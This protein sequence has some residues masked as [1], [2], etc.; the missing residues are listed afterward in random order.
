[1][2]KII[3]YSFLLSGLVMSGCKKYLETE[4]LSQASET[5]FWKT[6]DDAQTGLNAVYSTLPDSRDFWRDCHSDNSVMTNAWGEGGMGYICQGNQTPADTYISEEWAYADIRIALY[7]LDKLSAMDIDASMKKRFDA[8]AR[9]ILAM[10]YFRMTQLFGDIPLIKEKPVDLDASALPRS[11]KQE[12]LDYALQN[13]ETAVENLPESYSGADVGRITKGA[14]YLLKANIYL[15]MA[16]YKKFHENANDAALWTKAAEAADAVTTLGYDLEP[17]YSYLFKQQSNN[18]NTEVILAY[19]YVKDKL[20]QYLP[21]LAS[22]SGVGQTGEG[23]ASF[24]PTRDLIDSYE[25]TDGQSIETSPLYNKSNPFVNRD[26]RLAETFM[27]PGQP[28]IRPDGSTKPYNPHPSYNN[29]EKMN[30]EGGGLTGYMYLKFNDLTLLDPYTNYGNWPIYRYAEALLVLAEALNE[31]DPGNAKIQWAV[32]KIRA[33]AGLP[34]V[35]AIAGD[36]AKMR[37]AIREER[38]HEFVAEHKR[39]FDILRWKIAEDVLNVPAYGINSDVNDPIGDWTKP[40]FLA[41]DRHFDPAKHY[42]WPVPQTSIDKNNN[43]LPQNPNW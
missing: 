37:E 28:V 35:A 32:D 4:P 12:V 7:Y 27:L 16:S 19:Q 20:V 15:Y 17:D 24:C 3:A 29:P 6:V 26:K 5:T 34:G 8:E 1:M 43:L 40:K 2:K 31:Y 11:P 42:L 18:N 14:A 21:L 39:Y 41:Q 22:P 33:R 23:W 10:R 36:Q 13:V 25:T 38:R 9:F 30:A